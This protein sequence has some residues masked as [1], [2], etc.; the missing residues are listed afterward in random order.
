MSVPY[1]LELPVLSLGLIYASVFATLLQDTIDK[2]DKWGNGGE[3]GRIDP[4]IEI[5]DVSTCTEGY[6]F[7]WFSVD[8]SF[9]SS[10]SL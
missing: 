9:S 3:N 1:V 7:L 4:F 6:I 2:A 10:F 8:I 5:Y